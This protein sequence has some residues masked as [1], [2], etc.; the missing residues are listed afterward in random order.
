[1]FIHIIDIEVYD[2][3]PKLDKT[4]KI[5]TIKDGGRMQFA[6]ITEQMQNNY[7]GKNDI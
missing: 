4:L 2:L 7:G 5:Q 6:L 3:I 1:M